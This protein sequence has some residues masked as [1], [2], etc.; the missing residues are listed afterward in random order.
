MVA[1]T[2]ALVAAEA[3][4]ALS[5]PVRCEVGQYKTTAS[6]ASCLLKADAKGLSKMLTPDFSKCATKFTTNFPKYETNAG[7]GICPS[8]EGDVTTI[9]DLSD[10]YE[11]NVTLVL[12]GGTLPTAVCGD[13]TV[14]GSE[15]CDV[16][17]LNGD[18]CATQGFFNGTLACNPGCTF[19]TSGCNATRF[20]DNGTT[21]LDHQTGLEWEKKDNLGGGANL[22]NSHDAD[23][24]YTYAAAASTATQ[25]GTL[26]S[27]FLAKLNGTV[28]DATKT[29]TGCFASH[30]D[31]RIPTVDELKSIQVPC[32]AAPCIADPLLS[33][34]ASGRYWT[35]S[36]NP[37]SATGAYFVEFLNPGTLIAS[38]FKTAA[39]FARGVRT[40]P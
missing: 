21:V 40:Q 2:T 14:T 8:G 6:Y 16:G 38:D 12:N 9:K 27:D 13:G 20:E 34:S 35:N 39:H 15:D 25:S 7:M 1:I 5:D 32:G 37:S 10:D 24:T 28:V 36:T 29:T 31:W 30:C 4:A 11:A 26:Y 18:T 33:P 3:R 22:L 19:D 17:N 23:N